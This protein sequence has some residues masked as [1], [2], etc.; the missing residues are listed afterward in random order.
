MSVVR[1]QIDTPNMPV[2]IIQPNTNKD[3][4]PDPNGNLN[5]ASRYVATA[6]EVYYEYFHTGLSRY[7]VKEY[8]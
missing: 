4:S 5:D 2:L 8:S 1:F 3:V 6:Y 7:S